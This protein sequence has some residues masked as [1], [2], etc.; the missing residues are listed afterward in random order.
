[1]ARFVFKLQ[2]VLAQREREELAARRVMAEKQ[3]DGNK[4]RQ[5]LIDLNQSLV[6]SQFDLRSSH[7]TGRLDPNYLS[8]HRR[9]TIDV[10]RRG[11]DVLA[12]ITLADRAVEEARRGLALRT[13]RRRAIE[14][15][16]ETQER[17]WREGVERK[18]LA[19]ADDAS[20]RWLAG[21]HASEDEAMTYAS[22]EGGDA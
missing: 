6:K 3:R 5:E 21:I 1:M 4:L 9:F 18:E 10:S 20:S 15:L 11:R 13:Q 12:K 17:Q 22:T 19:E 2:S 7:L 8:A 14:R 16:R